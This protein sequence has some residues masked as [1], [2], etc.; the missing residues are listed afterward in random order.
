M[1][2]VTWGLNFSES[3]DFLKGSCYST[4]CGGFCPCSD[5]E[6]CV[7][8]QGKF[9]KFEDSLFLGKL[10]T[11]FMIIIL[12]WHILLVLIGVIYVSYIITL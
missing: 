1:L 2:E 12:Y 3:L 8:Y 6:V 9:N 11:E 7:K 4:V 10:L 5:A